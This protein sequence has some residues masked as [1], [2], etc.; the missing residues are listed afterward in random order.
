[1]KLKTK[2]E[3]LV[4]FYRS[5]VDGDVGAVQ[6]SRS[7]L[8]LHSHIHQRYQ[9]HSENFVPFG[10]IKRAWLSGPTVYLI[11]KSDGIMGVSLDDKR[12]AS[13][14]RALV[15][16]GVGED[17][18]RLLEGVAQARERY[19]NED[20]HIRPLRIPTYDP[21]KREAIIARLPLEDNADSTLVLNEL[22]KRHLAAI[23]SPRPPRRFRAYWSLPEGAGGYAELAYE[24]NPAG[25]GPSGEQWLLCRHDGFEHELSPAT[26]EHV[27][28]RLSK[29]APTTVY[30]EGV[31]E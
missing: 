4:A 13:D 28:S 12:A 15:G 24:M 20:V 5:E 21:S 11:N 26:E 14:L 16:A 19:G 2:D 17:E 27:L 29:S 25:S 7:G 23:H 6:V 10:E 18:Q 1:M 22:R 9:R 31:V 30:V 3:N 8:T